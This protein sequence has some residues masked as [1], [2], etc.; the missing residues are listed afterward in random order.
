[1]K[2]IAIVTGTRAEYGLLKPLIFA[3]RED[4][5]FDLKLLVT[6]M[7]LMPEFGNTYKE[8]EGDGLRI[9]AMIDDGLDGDSAKAITTSMGRALMGFA[10]VLAEQKPDLLIVLGDRTEILTAVTAAMVASIPIAHIH[11]GETTEGA[12][13]EFIRH[14]I[15][16]M[17]HY[18]FASTACYRDRII[19]MGEDPTRA[20]NVGAIG[21]DSIK[22]LKLLSKSEFEESIGIKLDKK[23]ALITFH[24]VT[25]ERATGGSQFGEI[26]KALDETQDTTL[27]FTKSNSDKEG[28]VINEMIDEYVSKNKDRAVAFTSLGQLR[29]LSALKHVDFVVGNSSSGIL[30]APYFKTPTINIGDRQKG[31]LMSESVISC[32]PVYKEISEAIVKAVDSV[33]LSKIQRQENIYGDGDATRRIM[34]ELKK[35]DFSKVKK[36]F[37]D[38]KNIHH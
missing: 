28:R 2:R 33:F 21:I 4:T 22:S 38:I 1:M 17:S 26:L 18:H 23:S 37:Y 14:A 32:A 10:E 20:F 5:D 25:L 30:E 34:S 7:H 8:I 19:Q 12:Y 31:R 27:I 29:Y 9:D 16:K 11:G 24:P 13:D 6:G 15:T 36:S 35:I 3:V